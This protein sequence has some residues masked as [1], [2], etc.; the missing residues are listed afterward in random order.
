[1]V[2][3]LL[4]IMIDT[5]DAA[6]TTLPTHNPMK[7]KIVS[8]FGV[9]LAVGF[10]TAASVQ[11]NITYQYIGNPFTD[12]N[13]PYTLTDRV[14]LSVEFASPLGANMAF[15]DVTPLVVAFSVS[16]G[17][18]TKTQPLSFDDHVEIGTGPSGLPQDWFIE[19]HTLNGEILTQG[20]SD[21]G[22]FDP[23]TAHG[24]NNGTPGVWSVSSAAPD[25]GSTLPLLS[26]SVTA[27]GVAARRF[28]R[29]AA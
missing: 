10:L 4:R 20:F 7:T 21:G 26:L 19:L 13:G 14:T 2:R 6:V 27:L 28:K 11:A 22:V 5:A 25:A 15:T 9:A 12:V 18:Q 16:D 29:E 1:M 24:V 8:F 23:L 17:V 3:K